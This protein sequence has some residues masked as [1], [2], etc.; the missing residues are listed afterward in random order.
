MTDT[1]VTVGSIPGT[2][3]PGRTR[4]RER[5]GPAEWGRARADCLGCEAKGSASPLNFPWNLCH[6][7]RRDRPPGFLLLPRGVCMSRS[8]SPFPSAPREIAA[9]G[10][11][12]GNKNSKELRET[13][14]HEAGTQRGHC[15]WRDGPARAWAG[16]WPFSAR[17]RA[18]RQPARWV[19]WGPLPSWVFVPQHHGHGQGP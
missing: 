11:S 15:P 6:R 12:H 8:L 2:R 10:L 16:D 18:C 14:A 19:L 4:S 17:S 7:H 13:S 9:E 1:R 5:P 3:A